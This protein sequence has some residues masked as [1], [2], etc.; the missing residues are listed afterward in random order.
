MGYVTIEKRGSCLRPSWTVPTELR[1][2]T[3]PPTAIDS[4]RREKP[5]CFL[6]NNQVRLASDPDPW[7]PRRPMSRMR[8]SSAPRDHIVSDPH[9]S[10]SVRSCLM[11]SLAVRHFTPESGFKRSSSESDS[12][13]LAPLLGGC[14]HRSPFFSGQ[15]HWSNPVLNDSG[16]VKGPSVGPSVVSMLARRPVVAQLAATGAVV[17]EQRQA[18]TPGWGIWVR[19]GS[20]PSLRVVRRLNAVC[21]RHRPPSQPDQHPA[22]RPR[23]ALK[24]APAAEAT[25]STSRAAAIRDGVRLPRT[26]SVQLA[27]RNVCQSRSIDGGAQCSR[28]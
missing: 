24:A 19:P 22:A 27:E 8:K 15:W 23:M 1:S 3:R 17:A 21:G 26:A 28:T 20:V 14:P 6:V 2:P 18:G 11:R 25:D 9:N 7:S 12:A 13:A 10:P 5:R 16:S 4:L